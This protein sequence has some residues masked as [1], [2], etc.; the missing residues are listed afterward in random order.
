MGQADLVV[1]AVVDGFLLRASRE[2]VS[3]PAAQLPP[4]ST[5]CATA[6]DVGSRQVLLAQPCPH[7]AASSGPA[8]SPCGPLLRTLPAPPCSPASAPTCTCVP[9]SSP[10]VHLRP[11]LQPRRAPVSLPPAPTCTCVSSSSL[12]VH[13]RP[14]LQTRAASSSAPA[15]TPALP[16]PRREARSP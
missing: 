9:S 2:L 7:S 16:V 10:D 15:T 11:F 4:K 1:W 12:D 8:R 5:T 14:F 3:V 13:L 6:D